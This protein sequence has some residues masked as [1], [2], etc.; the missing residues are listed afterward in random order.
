MFAT[1]EELRDF[2]RRFE[3]CELRPGEFRHRQHL[4][5]GAF[6]ICESGPALARKR[7][8]DGLQRFVRHLGKEE[9]Y[10]EQLTMEWMDRICVVI[11]ATT[12][13]TLLGRVN[14]V[15]EHYAPAGE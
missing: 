6:Y 5:L 3:T 11:T 1:E 4:A 12:A 14:A 15:V 9:R 7:M 13:K 2:I 10:N 8:R